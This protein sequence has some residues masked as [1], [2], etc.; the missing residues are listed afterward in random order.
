MKPPP[1]HDRLYVAVAGGVR[2]RI[3]DGKISV[4]GKVDGPPPQRL[5]SIVED[6]ARG[7]DGLVHLDRDGRGHWKIATRGELSSAGFDQRLR[8]VLG[9]L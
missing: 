1:W 2:I 7:A 8:N 9:N 6:L 3:A 5:V 4:V